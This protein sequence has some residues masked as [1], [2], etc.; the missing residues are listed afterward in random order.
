MYFPSIA[1]SHRGKFRLVRNTFPIPVSVG[2]CNP[3]KYWNKLT[4]MKPYDQIQSVPR[5]V[6]PTY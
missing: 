3:C 4:N 6:E 1:L 2:D 5:N